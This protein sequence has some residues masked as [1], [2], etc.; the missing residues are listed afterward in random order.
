MCVCV[1]VHGC[2]CWEIAGLNVRWE[3]LYAFFC[4]HTCFDFVRVRV[5]AR[6][7]RNAQM[8]SL[9]FSA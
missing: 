6:A 5:C 2:V 4:M 1:C 9:L 3:S 7:L 8:A